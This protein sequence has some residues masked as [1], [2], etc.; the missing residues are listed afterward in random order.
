MTFGPNQ[1]IGFSPDGALLAVCSAH[2][3][4][5]IDARRGQ[6]LRM[7][8]GHAGTVTDAAFSP[9]GDVIVTG[10]HDGTARAW[11]VGTGKP[12]V[13]FAGHDGAVCAVAFPPD[14]KR[15]ATASSDETACV[16]DAASGAALVTMAGHFGAV[17]DVAFSPDGTRLA[18]ASTLS[19]LVWDAVTGQRDASLRASRTSR[20][21][22]G[23]RV[24]R[25]DGDHLG[26]HDWHSG[27]KAGGTRQFGHGGRV[28][29]RF[30]VRPGGGRD[31]VTGRYRPDLGRGHGA[32][33]RR[34]GRARILDQRTRLR[35]VGNRDRHWV[36]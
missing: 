24:H 30:P 31:R 34:I 11:E 2:H 20:S 14:G 3:V 15:I 10:S 9:G 22:A 1:G 33:R 36:R 19:A 27:G 12:L 26:C 21:A 16:W 8:R 23:H 4:E 13:T 25:Q 32:A 5:I 6:A 17:H 7:I 18:T 29:P 28:F 35:A